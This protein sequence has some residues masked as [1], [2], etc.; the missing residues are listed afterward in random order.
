MLLGFWILVW[1]WEEKR[2]N[3]RKVNNTKVFLLY[4]RVEG[5]SWRLRAA[6]LYIMQSCFM[7]GLSINYS[8]YRHLFQHTFFNDEKE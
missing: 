5:A 8:F 3:E 1:S 7:L 2:G 6:A 4:Y